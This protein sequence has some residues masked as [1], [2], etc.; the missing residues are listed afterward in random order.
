MATIKDV[1]REA[2]LTV[3]TVSRVLNNRGYISEA[4]RE[5][6][7]RVMK[8]LN[9]QPNEVA[10][11][12]SKSKTNTIGV[13]VPHIVHPYFAKLISNLEKAASDR[14]YK[15]L[16]C[17][18]REDQNRE[19]EYLDML[20][21]NRVAGLILCSARVKTES[22]AD[23]GIPVITIERS[24][25]AG[26]ASVECDNYQGG[27]MAAEH[28][29]AC[30]CKYIINLGGVEQ[31]KMPADSR[32]TGFLDV[33]G[34][35]GVT[36]IGKKSLED[37]YYAMEYHEYIEKIIMENPQADGIFA[38]SDLLA[39]QVLQVCAKL[40][41]RV[42]EQMK[43]V[44]FDD[45]NVASLTTPPITTIHQPVREMAETAVELI[46]KSNKGEMI[47]TRT[48]LPVSLVKRGTTQ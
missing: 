36:A 25:G 11:S 26:T 48:L 42:P 30:G 8:E 16:L 31:T 7:Y 37:E 12:L 2:G 45:V 24:V 22:L 5:N 44:G 1:A 43:V 39:A 35:Y 13:I 10:R 29:I 19:Q 47:P 27:I 33:C 4:T 34:R 20:K 17:N 14:G 15:M 23:L 46:I 18:S 3:G 32:E 9:Y 40:G 21:S 6:V 41:I 28:L 38:S